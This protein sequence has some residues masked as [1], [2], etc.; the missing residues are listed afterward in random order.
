MW[1]HRNSPLVLKMKLTMILFLVNLVAIH[2]NSNENNDRAD[3]VESMPKTSMKCGECP[4]GNPCSQELPPPSPPPPAPAPPPKT[5]QNCAPPPPRFY[6]FSNPGDQTAQAVTPPPPPRFTY[7][8]GGGPPGNLYPTDP[9]SLEIYN[10]ATSNP[11]SSAAFLGLF[12][13]VIYGL[14]WGYI[15]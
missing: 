15:V 1:K 9:Y 10:A 4:C 14:L 12:L 5:T 13:F 11:S 8:I 7:I 3:L 6:Y 2:A